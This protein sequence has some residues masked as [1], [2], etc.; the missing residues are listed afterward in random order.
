MAYLQYTLAMSVHKNN[1]EE[2][3]TDDSE[4]DDSWR[5]DSHDG[6]QHG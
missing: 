4:T 2:V 1:G 3:E 6:E 5:D